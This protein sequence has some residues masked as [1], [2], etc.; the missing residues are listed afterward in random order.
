[1]ADLLA[2]I[3]SERSIIKLTQQLYKAPT[4][5]IALRITPPDIFQSAKE[6]KNIFIIY[7]LLLVLSILHEEF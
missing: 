1:M 4:Y 6:R 2:H 5:K 7:F 3:I